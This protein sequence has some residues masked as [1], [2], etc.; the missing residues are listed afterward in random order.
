MKPLPSERTGR[1]Y[2][3]NPKIAKSGGTRIRD[4]Y[5]YGGGLWKV[6]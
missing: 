4:T 3:G 2:R 6:C 5:H 1:G